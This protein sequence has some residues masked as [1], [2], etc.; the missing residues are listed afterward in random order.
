MELMKILMFLF[1]VVS[2]FAV[3]SF[4]SFILAHIF[5]L[6]CFFLGTLIIFTKNIFLSEKEI[7]ILSLGILFY[8]ST[9]IGALN[10]NLTAGLITSQIFLLCLLTVF[11][12]FKIDQNLIYIYLKGFT[13][14]GIITSLYCMVDYI[15]FIKF[16]QTIT[17]A[18]F[19]P[20]LLGKAMGHTFVN[21][22]NIKGIVFYRPSGLSW[23]PGFSITG[24]ALSFVM[25]NEGIVKY[26][27]KKLVLL[28]MVIGMLLSIS[29]ASIITVLTYLIFKLFQN[30]NLFFSHVK[31]SVI[32]LLTFLSFLVFLYIGLF[33]NPDKFN[34]DISRHLKYF[35][36]IFYVYRENLL[37][38]LFGYG[39][40]GIGVYFNRY[41]GWLKRQGEIPPN[42]NPESTLTD[43][44]FY[45][46]L[47]GASFWVYSFIVAF[48]KGDSRIKLVLFSMLLLT[49][50]YIITSVWFNTVYL[51]VILLAINN[52]S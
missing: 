9:L 35:S 50:G 17:T 41:V 21:L 1:G 31:F 30:I 13:Y 46:G 16:N 15:Y 27:F 40:T 48:K 24:I 8:A 26:K 5:L 44:F 23:D 10:S 20:A 29:K 19:P 47:V 38:F 42:L 36:S 2:L 45:G 28:I 7:F 18:I 43:T 11:I 52:K 49:Y 33:I 25:V 14:S 12:A 6:G 32:A 51:S 4:H 37:G 34:Q 39:Y 3:P 22:Q